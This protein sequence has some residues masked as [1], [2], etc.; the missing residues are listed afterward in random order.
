VIL[1]V[2][3]ATAVTVPLLTVAI[4]VLLLAHDTFLFVALLGWTVA[5]SVSCA[6]WLSAMT[7]LLRL[8]PVTLMVWGPG[9]G[10][11]PPEQERTRK[12]RSRGRRGVVFVIF[13]PDFF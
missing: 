8:T 1:A 4:Y 9:S 6:P 2:P 3:A 13:L 11:F 10:S 12:V 7:F 5:T